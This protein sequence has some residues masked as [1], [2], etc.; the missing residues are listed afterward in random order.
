MKGKYGDTVASHTTTAVNY[1]TIKCC[2]GGCVR[3]SARSPGYVLNVLN[4]DSW[5][6]EYRGSSSKSLYTV[7]VDKMWGRG[8]VF[9]Q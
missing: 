6:T 8:L 1:A 7:N 2:R 3:H 5:M 9:G 4:D